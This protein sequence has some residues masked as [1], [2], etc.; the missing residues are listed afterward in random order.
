MAIGLRVLHLGIQHVVRSVRVDPLGARATL[1]GDDGVERLVDVELDTHGW[2][3]RTYGVDLGDEPTTTARPS[4]QTRMRIE[5]TDDTAARLRYMSGARGVTIDQ[6]VEYLVRDAM[7]GDSDEGIESDTKA[8]R[9]SNPARRARR[10]ADHHRGRD[11]DAAER[12]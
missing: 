6:I 5:M 4:T 7:E 8:R 12:E 10:G 2:V 1:A 11:G 3:Y 9:V